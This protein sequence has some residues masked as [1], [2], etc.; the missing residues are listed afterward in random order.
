M[1]L[2]RLCRYRKNL[3][4]PI[5]CGFKIVTKTFYTFEPNVTSIDNAN[6]NRLYEFTVKILAVGLYYV[7]LLSIDPFVLNTNNKTFSKINTNVKF[8][9]TTNIFYDTLNLI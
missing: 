4:K 5:N 6:V 8:D 9:E 1:P 7:Q 2:Y 3:W